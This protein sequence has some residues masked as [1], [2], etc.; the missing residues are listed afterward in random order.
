MCSGL[1][2]VSVQTVIQP[3]AGSSAGLRPAASLPTA[4]K[5]CPRSRRHVY[6]TSTTPERRFDTIGF[7]GMYLRSSRALSPVQDCKSRMVGAPQ[8]VDA[9]S[10]RSDAGEE[11][12]WRRSVDAIPRLLHTEDVRPDLLG[13]CGPHRR[14]ECLQAYRLPSITACG[15]SA[16]RGAVPGSH[17]PSLI[18]RKF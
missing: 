16:C 12:S 1:C 13:K 4:S 6:L 8:L 9:N 10:A 17:L 5:S 14:G 18:S 15:Q 7:V 3:S 2:K 11:G